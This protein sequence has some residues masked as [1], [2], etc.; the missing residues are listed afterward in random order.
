[1]FISISKQQMKF[2]LCNSTSRL[3]CCLILTACLLLKL[4][5][6]GRQT[7]A[8]DQINENT[9]LARALSSGFTLGGPTFERGGKELV[10]QEFL[11]DLHPAQ[12]K[13]TRVMSA[14]RNIYQSRETGW[15]R[16]DSLKEIGP[17]T[18]LDGSRTVD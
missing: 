17:R 8:H 2:L 5:T 7:G 3:L 18:T 6:F 16:R 11:R 4:Q 9:N 14:S 10:K 12:N 13:H 15:N 1:M